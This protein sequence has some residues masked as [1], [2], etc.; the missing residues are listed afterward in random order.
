MENTNFTAG[1]TFTS[2]YYTQTDNTGQPWQYS[3]E[4]SAQLRHDFSERFSVNAAESFIDSPEPNIYGTTGTPYRDGQNL[5]NA[6][7]AGFSGQWTPLIGSQ[8]TYSNTIVRYTDN[9]PPPLRPV[10]TAWRTR[11][12]NR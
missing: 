8:T 11:H 1:Y 9:K 10:R 12:P 5:S 4:F 3:N 7:T 6:F 2:T